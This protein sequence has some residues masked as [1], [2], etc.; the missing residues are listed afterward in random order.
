MS[1]AL[2]INSNTW[3]SLECAN[4]FMSARFGAGEHWDDLS[5]TEKSAALITAFKQ[6][7]NSGLFS[8]P[9]AATPD[10]RDAQ[11]EQALFIVQHQKD[12]DQRL[13]LQAQGVTSAGIVKEQY[14]DGRA[15]IAISPI[16]LRYLDCYRTQGSALHVGSINRDEEMDV[17]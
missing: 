15:D 1:S 13:G 11:C 10:I 9:A 5:D 14:K 4:E 16:V 3:I 7:K 2:T 17:I 6:I 8:F 12:A